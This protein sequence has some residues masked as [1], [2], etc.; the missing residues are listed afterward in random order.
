MSEAEITLQP[1]RAMDQARATRHPIKKLYFWTLHWAETKWA[2]PAL[3]L[4]AFVESSFFLIPP[5][6]LLMAMVFGKREKWMSYALWCTIGSVAGAVLGWAIGWWFWDATS[7][8][9]YN[10]IPGFTPEKFGKVEVLYQNNAWLAILA[11]AFTPIPYKIFTIAS[12]VMHVSLS[13]LIPASIIGRGARFF[14]VAG[15]IRWMGPRVRP[16]LE[17]HFDLASLVFLLLAIAGFA[18]IKFLH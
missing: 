7:G 3:I 14:L 10:V 5:D 15:L 13:I 17:K 8:F 18:A 16:F 12:G 4:V 6:V 9:F 2:L 11:S 1:E